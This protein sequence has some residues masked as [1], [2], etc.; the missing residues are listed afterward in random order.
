MPGKNSHTAGSPGPNGVLLVDKPAGMSSHGV[1]SR[2]RKWCGTRKVGHAG[3]LDPMATGVLVLGIGRGTKLLTYFV[4]LDKTYT[5][6]IR[7][8]SSTPTDDADSAPD[9]FADP[10]RLTAVTEEDIAAGVRAL[11]GDILQRPSA[12]SAI[13][14]DGRRSYARVRAGEDVELEERPVT[15]S[16]FEIHEIRRIPAGAEG[17]PAGAPGAEAA[18]GTADAEAALGAID[19]DVTVTCSSGTYIRALARDLGAGLGV[20]GHLTALRRTRV[21]PFAEAEVLAL[22]AWPD[23]EAGIAEAPAPALLPLASAAGRVLPVVPLDGAERLA[24]SQGKILP[25]PAELPESP[26]GLWAGV[27]E[28]SLVAVLERARGGLKSAA[29]IE[30]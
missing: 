19:I 29:G 2:V 25:L 7:L 5:A 9:T 8:G 12:V 30:V 17:P 18:R 13:K 1:V 21:G 15:V 11:T 22:P 16:A 26:R 10:T 24:I 6:S 3:T 14:V 28:G 4:G 27:H 20:H 23:P